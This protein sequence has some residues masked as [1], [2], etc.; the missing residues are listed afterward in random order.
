[1]NGIAIVKEIIQNID[2]ENLCGTLICVPVVNIFGF[3][4]NTR[5]LNDGHDLNRF[6]PGDPNNWSQG[7]YASIIYNE[8]VAKSNYLIDLHTASGGKSN[9]FHVRADMSNEKIAIMANAF[10]C[11]V[12]MDYEGTKGSLRKSATDNGIPSILL[13]AGESQ[14]ISRKYTSRGVECIQNVM[15]K[16]NMI[17][18]TMKQSPLS[19][20]VKKVT[21]VRANRGGILTIKTS[22]GRVVKKGKEIAT[23]SNPFGKEVES[24]KAPFNGIVIGIVTAPTVIPGQSVCHLLKIDGSAKDFREE[25]V[26]LFGNKKILY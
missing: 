11:S 13:E 18:G 25:L 9:L 2:P 5:Y 8:L 22:P 14:K 16:L 21:W 10:G 24:I 20:V 7:R 12:I 1:M 3:Q 26:K 15:I 23:S 4:N 6:F 17:E 19:I